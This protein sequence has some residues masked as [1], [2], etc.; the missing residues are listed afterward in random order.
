MEKNKIIQK[1][2]M[3]VLKN[4]PEHTF[5]C[6]ISDPPYNISIDEWDKI[7][8]YKEFTKDWISEVIRVTKPNKAIWVFGNQHNI[9]I[10]KPILDNNPLV[11]FRSIIIWNKGV[12]IPSC[13]NFSD[14]Y[15][16]ILYYIKVPDFKIKKSFGDYIKKRRLELN[17]SLKEI[18]NLCNEKWYHRGGQ[19]YFETG[20]A[21]PTVKQYFQLK[22]IL[23]LN[24]Q[25]DIWFDNH[26]IF[27][28]ESI[29]V[30]WK[31][32][33]D[34]R[35]KRGWKN[36]GNVWYISQLSGAFK[37]RE[38]HPTQ[39]PISLIS[40]MIKVSSNKGDLVLDLFA[41]TGTTSLVAKQLN[42]KFICI[43]LEDRYIK[44]I[45]KRLSQECLRS[46]V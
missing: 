15:E 43:E 46:F 30:K 23:K 2:V 31:Y 37:E 24:N 27:N 5:D 18:G 3:E 13:Y 20:L 14:L 7:D 39:K 36:P 17:I 26:F 33:K 38:A 8:N 19:L 32:D 6:I 11:A 29:G 40:R 25:F 44:I 42:R 35:N 41:G 28:L 9:S 22:E 12:G 45:N 10:M 1:D 21:K 4:T 16:E 34:K